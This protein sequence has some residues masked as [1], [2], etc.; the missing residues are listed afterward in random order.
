MIYYGIAAAVEDVV[1]EVIKM[2]SAIG[3][4]RDYRL[5]TVIIEKMRDAMKICVR[6]ESDDWFGSARAKVAECRS[7]AIAWT[8]RD[9]HASETYFAIKKSCNVIGRLIDV[10]GGHAGVSAGEIMEISN[11]K[12]ASE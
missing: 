3:D 2:R 5:A 10:L 9:I 1:D 12:G 7:D 6:R 4:G 8:D 11:L